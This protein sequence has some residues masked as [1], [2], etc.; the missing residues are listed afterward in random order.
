MIKLVKYDNKTTYMFPSGKIAT[1]AVMQEE[2]PAVTV[3]PH[4]IQVSGNVCQA[5]MELEALRSMHNIDPKLTDDEALTEIE[6]IMNAPEPEP[7]PT[8][9]E[10][11]AAALEYQ[12]M[13]NL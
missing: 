2:F 4:V 3:F 13:M 6:K 12:N 7:E 5:V 8:A 11:I 10:R 9:D 1:P